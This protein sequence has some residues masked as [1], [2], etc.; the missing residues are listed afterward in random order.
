MK[1]KTKLI[2]KKKMLTANLED[3]VR[4]L[5]TIADKNMNQRLSNG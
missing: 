2:A 1:S 4:F 3:Y 5:A